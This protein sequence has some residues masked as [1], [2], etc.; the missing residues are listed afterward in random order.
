MKKLI[1][2]LTIIAAGAT[3]AIAQDAPTPGDKPDRPHKDRGDRGGR[4]NPEEVFKHLDADNSGS[5]SLE[6]FKANP[7]AQKNPEKA[8]ERFKALDTNNDGAVSLEEFKAGRPHRDHGPKGEEQGKEE[9]ST[10]E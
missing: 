10:Q 3:L 5:V 6:E 8:E 4:K 9:Q 1:T 7:R 2:T